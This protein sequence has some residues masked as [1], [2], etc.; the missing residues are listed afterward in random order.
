[1]LTLHLL[2]TTEKESGEAYT[3]EEAPLESTSR[4]AQPLPATIRGK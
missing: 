4:E 3:T 2:K 1:M